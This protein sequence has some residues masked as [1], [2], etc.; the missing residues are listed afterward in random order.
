MGEDRPGGWEAHP[1]SR[2]GVYKEGQVETESEL[3][4][5]MVRVVDR[6][7]PFSLCYPGGYF[8]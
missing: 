6:G 5:L 7:A 3:A 1:S 4:H 2:T 8:E